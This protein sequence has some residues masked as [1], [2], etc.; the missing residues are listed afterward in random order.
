MSKGGHGEQKALFAS[1]VR[2]DGVTALR[3]KHTFKSSGYG[4]NCVLHA[5]SSL[6]RDSMELSMR[7]SYICTCAPIYVV[8]R[9]AER[10][11]HSVFAHGR[12]ARQ[13][14]VESPRFV[15][16]AVLIIAPSALMKTI[17][18]I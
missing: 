14:N 3:P 2:G 1:R 12:L 8:V 6:F 5:A 4:G 15:Q 13:L 17:A 18:V 11:E 9:C 10:A 16:P 7:T